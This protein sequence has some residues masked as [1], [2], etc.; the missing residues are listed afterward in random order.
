MKVVISAFLVFLFTSSAYGISDPGCNDVEVA[1]CDT[2]N[3]YNGDN[4][5]NLQGNWLKLKR[6]ANIELDDWTGQNIVGKN[7][8]VDDGQTGNKFCIFAYEE[9][10]NGVRDIH[11]YEITMQADNGLYLKNGSTEIP[12]IVSLIKGDKNVK[13]D[14][15]DFI[16]G[17][18][19]NISAGDLPTSTQ[20]NNL[21]YSISVS[22]NTEDVVNNT[23]SSGTYTG[24]FSLSVS[25]LESALTVEENFVIT[26]EVQPVIQIS[27]LEDMQV[28]YTSGNDVEM[29]QTFCVYTLGK[30]KF[31]I[32]G[33][34]SNGNGSGFVLSNSN[35]AIP[36]TVSVGRRGNGQGNL[37]QLV[38]GADYVS[39]AS[40]SGK[41][42]Q[43]CVSSGS[44]NMRLNLDISENNISDKPAGVYKDTVTLTVAL[45]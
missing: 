42:T 3:E 31:K 20:C 36:Y 34:S 13:F 1:A 15:T 29:E 24:T 27:G 12:V 30:E 17:K 39:H 35:E 37:V 19:V 40:W 26:V 2:D 22:L 6:L 32:R 11:D 43:Y 14:Q 25:S 41:K 21:D 23:T 7:P 16:S 44:E 5:E 45:E 10:A 38:D 8:D 33:G 18:I 9:Y 28:S 4:P